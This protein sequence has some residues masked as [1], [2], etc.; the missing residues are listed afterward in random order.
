MASR[1]T[2]NR[3]QVRSAEELHL[4]RTHVEA[5]MLREVLKTFAGRHVLFSILAKAEIYGDVMSSDVAE[6]NRFLGR[7][8]VGLEVLTEVL[9]ARPDVYIIMQKEGADF[10]AKY[11]LLTEEREDG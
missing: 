7:R 8:S 10:E 1:D 2:S 11:T 6:T 5:E 9:T 3:E 4:L